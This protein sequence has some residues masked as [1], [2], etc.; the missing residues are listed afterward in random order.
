MPHHS[1]NHL[2]NWD[3]SNVTRYAVGMFDSTTIGVM[4]DKHNLSDETITSNHLQIKTYITNY[5][6]GQERKSMLCF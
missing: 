4:L 5:L 3:V 6:S 1:T 2:N